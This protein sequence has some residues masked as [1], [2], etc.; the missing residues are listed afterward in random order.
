MQAFMG[1]GSALGFIVAAYAVYV[2]KSDIQLGIAVTGFFAGMILWGLAVAV[3]HLSKME[4]YAHA[5]WLDQ[6]PDRK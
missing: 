1:I 5:A 4:G 3:G 6:N 2:M